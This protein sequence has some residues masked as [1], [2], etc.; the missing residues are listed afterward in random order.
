MTTEIDDML[1]AARK[2]S[3]EGVMPGAHPLKPQLP[4][5]TREMIRVA[6]EE[7]RP[8]LASVAAP[9]PMVLGS[10]LF[11]LGYEEAMAGAGLDV[12]TA[13]SFFDIGRDVAKAVRREGAR[14]EV[15]TGGESCEAQPPPWPSGS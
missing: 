6:L 14:A 4:P 2:A 9:R 13:A 7:V 1:S 15:Q 10:L 8:L 3:E 5:H 11:L 12:V